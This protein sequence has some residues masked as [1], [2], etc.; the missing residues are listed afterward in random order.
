MAGREKELEAVVDQFIVVVFGDRILT[1]GR[2]SEEVGEEAHTHTYVPKV[3]PKET[4][5]LQSSFIPVFI[6]LCDGHP[7]IQLLF[8]RLACKPLP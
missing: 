7:A 6:R 5:Q 1:P 4:I 8:R 2:R 3:V